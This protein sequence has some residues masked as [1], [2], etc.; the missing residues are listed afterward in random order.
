MSIRYNKN[1]GHVTCYIKFNLTINQMTNTESNFI[2][3]NRT[4][5]L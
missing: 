3:K 1:S 4:N 5:K 2:A